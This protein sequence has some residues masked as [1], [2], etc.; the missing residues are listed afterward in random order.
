MK[1]QHSPAQ[2]AKREVRYLKKQNFD[3]NSTKL[4]LEKEYGTLFSHFTGLR[5]EFIDQKTLLWKVN[6]DN[7]HFLEQNEQLQREVKDQAKIIEIY[8]QD[9][10]GNLDEIFELERKLKRSKT[11]LFNTSAGLLVLAVIEV[12]NYLI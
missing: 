12:V 2:K 4:K 3:Q 11:W 1:R 10:G 8:Y 9:I 7:E 6:K 5:N